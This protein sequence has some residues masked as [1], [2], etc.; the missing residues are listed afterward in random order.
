VLTDSHRSG[1]PL[2]TVPFMRQFV[3][4]SGPRVHQRARGSCSPQSQAPWFRAT[5][6]TRPHVVQRAGS[7]LR[8]CGTQ[9]LV[10]ALAERSPLIRRLVPRRPRPVPSAPYPCSAAPSPISGPTAARRPSASRSRQLTGPAGKARLRRA[11]PRSTT[12]SFVSFHRTSHLRY[13]PGPIPNGSPASWPLG[14]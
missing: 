10:V 13:R 7:A 4:A 3:A 5:S 6:D 9:T 2:I 12:S 8:W 14:P 11:H 1:K